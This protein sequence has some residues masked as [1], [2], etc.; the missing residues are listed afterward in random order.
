MKKLT[1]IIGLFF[2]TTLL[3]A[4][5]IYV[6]VHNVNGSLV[7]GAIVDLYDEDW[8]YISTQY[9]NSS[10]MAT[11]ALLDYGYYN[12][13]VYY[14]GDVIEFWGSDED[15]YL[16]SPTTIRQF[17]REWP[18]LYDHSFSPTNPNV[19]EE[20]TIDIIVKNNLSYSRSVKVELW[21]DRNQSSP[22]DFHETSSA[23]TVYGGSTRTFTFSM[24][25]SSSGTYYWKSHIKTYND[26]A[27]TYIVTDTYTWEEAF[28]AY[29]QVGD[30]DVYVY[31]INENTVS[32]ATVKLYDEDWNYLESDDTNSSGRADFDDLSYGTYNYEVYYDSDET[33]F[34]GS[35]EDFE[36]NSSNVTRYF[37][38]NWPYLFDHSFSPTSPNI[39]EEVTVD[40]IVKNNLSYSRSVKVELWVDRNQSSPWDFHETSSA[41]TVY[42]GSTRTFTFSM[43]PSSSGTYY[44]KS[45][46]KTYNDGA[47]TY[48]VT[49]T[50]PWSDAFTVSSPPLPELDGIIA[51]HTYSGFF[52]YDGIIHILDLSNYS[53]TDLNFSDWDGCTNPHI[54]PDGLKIVFIA[55]P[56]NEHQYNKLEI[57]LYNLENGI[58][59]RLTNNNVADEDPKF[60]P[61]GNFIVF[62]RNNDLYQIEVSSLEETQI[63]STSTVEEWAPFYSRYGSKIYYTH[64]ENGNDNI[65]QIDLN[66]EDATPIIHGSNDEWYPQTICENSFFYILTGNSD[67]VYKYDF[68]NGISEYLITNSSSDDSDPF[69][70]SGNYFGFSSTRDG[71]G[72]DLYIGDIETGDIW[73]IYGDETSLDV[74]GGSYRY[75][76]TFAQK[77]NFLMILHI[78]VLM[79]LN[80]LISN[81]IFVLNKVA[82]VFI[83]HNGKEIIFLL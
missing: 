14:P 5:T 38:R 25:P 29:E 7:S 28:T 46:I 2:I 26:G 18:Y 75:P 17:W 37:T 72:Y 33:E 42:G 1:I 55:V 31:N 35:D 19:G 41:Q 57:L 62:K 30:L 39:G 44:W 43:T 20:V 81:G 10:G 58:L 47:G 82:L 6:Y 53:T 50:Y 65:W 79:I 21:V 80:F 12:Y 59:S 51:F 83:V 24:T 67:D 52:N 77:M 61:G 9:T 8:Y 3:N 36:I 76:P 13:E 49:D 73:K 60:S 16:G 23:Q 27:G 78:Q 63:T 11:F 74:L 4:A 45:H 64:R 54:S 71:Y 69:F 66:S 68:T 22:W 56:H 70:I 48:I 15:F 32:G 34:W 40:I